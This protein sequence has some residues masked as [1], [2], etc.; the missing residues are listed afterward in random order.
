MRVMKKICLSLI[1]IFS[2]LLMT[3][4][5][6]SQ[7]AEMQ[8]V[9]IYS[10]VEPGLLQALE[11]NF[12]LTHK[13]KIRLVSVNADKHPDLYLASGNF[14]QSIEDEKKLAGFST[15]EGDRVDPAFKSAEDKWIGL[16]YDP[17]VMLVN[18]EFARKTGQKNI[19]H[20]QDIL[21]MEDVRVVMDNLSDSGT[22][23]EILAAMASHL[24]EERFFNYLTLLKP[25]I[26]RY[27]K[28]P[29]TSIRLTATGDA[30]IAIIQRSAIFKY[31]Q[32]DFPAY[33][34]YPDEGAPAILYGIG[35]DK[36]S[37]K[38]KHVRTFVSWLLKSSEAGTAFFESG[39][40]YL[41]LF[42][43]GINGKGVNK[44]TLWLNR[45]YKNEEEIEKLRRL[46]LSNIRL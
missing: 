14:L 7:P 2:C 5:I 39:S 34:M 18:Q 44:N 42:P 12:N 11:E 16:F 6:T 38:R 36:D 1:L 40:G 31:L 41:L 21:H 24:G 13:Q 26:L 19:C 25:H 9:S 8:T 32:D 30:D 4:C 27:T 43:K 20:W 35:I 3:S 10:E 46:W 15:V 23:G 17:V 33:I 22:G 29:I 28:F 45:K 37:V